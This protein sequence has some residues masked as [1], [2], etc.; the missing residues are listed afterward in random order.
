MDSD[1]LNVGILYLCIHKKLEE[2]TGISRI[3]P[4]KAFFRMIGETFHVPKN[5][6]VCVQKEMERMNLIK[7]IGTKR[8]TDIEVLKVEFD[9]ENDASKFYQWLG[10]WGEDENK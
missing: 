3:L 10:M 2:R 5:M 7:E 6:R 1:K 4:K 9:L 8:E